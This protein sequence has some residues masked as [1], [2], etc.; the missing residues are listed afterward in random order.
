M[1]TLHG[2]A[3]AAGRWTAP[4]AAA[5]RTAL[6]LPAF[7]ELAEPQVVAALAAETEAA[8]FDGFF[9]WDHLLYRP[10]HEVIAD[11][12]VVL[13]AVAC[14]TERLRIGPMVT[15]VPRRRPQVL[16]RQTATLDRLSGGRLTFGAGL[17]GDPGGELS[18]FGE[19]LDPR[20]RAELL[21]R[22]LE[23]IVDAWTGGFQPAPVQRPRPPVWLGA[24]WPHRTPLRRAARFEGV[25][26]VAIETPRDVEQLVGIVAAQ[27]GSVDGFDIAVQ[28]RTGD[29]PRPYAAAGATWWFVRIEPGDGAAEARRAIAAGPPGA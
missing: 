17:G 20:R 25:F 21:D 5:V 11:P 9:V 23:F 16:A 3:T 19:E 13:A 10:P 6:F 28:G 2:E 7:G 22:G 1:T 18:R 8:G 4:Y 15:P 24:V 14:L 29:D 26:P 12:W 27:R